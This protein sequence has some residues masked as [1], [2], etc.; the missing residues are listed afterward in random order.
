MCQNKHFGV[1][2]LMEIRE[3]IKIVKHAFLW[4]Q[5]TQFCTQRK[6]ELLP[7]TQVSE[8]NAILEDSAFNMKKLFAK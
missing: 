1:K 4:N 3:D 8:I 6:Y 5:F 2:F 7:I